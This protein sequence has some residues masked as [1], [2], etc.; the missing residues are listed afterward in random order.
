MKMSARAIAAAGTLLLMAASAGAQSMGAG[1]AV[2]TVLTK[3]EGEVPSSVAQQDMAIKLDGKAAKVTKWKQYEP[4]NKIELVLLID[5]GARSSLGRQMGDIQNFINALPPNILAGIAYMQNGQALFSGP[6]SADHATV[7]KNLHVT[8]GMV[9]S[10]ASPYF[11]LSDLARQWPG[12]DPAARREVV[13]ITD[14]VDPYQQQFDPSDPY[15]L[16]SINDAVHARLVVYAIYW[17]SRGFSVAAQMDTSAGQNLLGEVAAATGGKSFYMG[18]GNPVSF[19]GYFQELIRR[20]RNQWELGFEGSLNGRPQVEDLRL[21]MHAPG[22]EID[23][24]QRVLLDP[25]A[26]R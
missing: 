18:T 4:D 3:H 11:C 12:Q 15:V 21:K 9:G 26:V 8:G 1:Q 25:A 24:P 16:A 6:L 22:T 10:S 5:G 14:G 19:E 7:L 20:F 2:V 17:G 23:A 13:M